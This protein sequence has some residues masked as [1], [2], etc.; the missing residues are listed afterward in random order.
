VVD[1]ALW[2]TVQAVRATRRTRDGR[3]SVRRAYALTMLHCSDCGRH[4]IGDTGRYRHPDACEAFTAVR[5][6]PRK[7]FQGQRKNM[8]G[9]SYRADEYEAIVREELAHVSL[10]AE[11][12]AAVVAGTRDAEPDR[13]A[14]ARIGR[15]RDAALARYRR[16]RDLRT[17]E[18]TMAALDE[19]EAE[20]NAGGPVTALEA[21]EVGAYLRDLPRLWDDAPGSRRALAEALFERVEVLGLRRMRIEPTPSAVAAGLSEAFS[22]ASAGHGRGERHSPATTDLPITMRLAGPPEPFDWLRSA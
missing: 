3:P 16:D 17:L 5:R 15:E 7:R 8:P 12:V 6:E 13:L 11:H 9:A 22:R 18:R 21:S 4:L 14:I 2:E 19:Q 20:A 1:P 10:G